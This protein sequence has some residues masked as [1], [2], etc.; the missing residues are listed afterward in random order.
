MQF[1]GSRLV[2]YGGGAF[3]ELKL[4]ALYRKGTQFC[5]R[6]YTCEHDKAPWGVQHELTGTR[7]ECINFLRY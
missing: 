6:I 3:K 2:A 1:I 7:R 4:H 5:A